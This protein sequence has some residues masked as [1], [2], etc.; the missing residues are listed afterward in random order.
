[1]R[2]RHPGIERLVLTVNLRNAAA[3]STYLK[4]GFQDTGALY[5]GGDSG[6]QH[7]FALPLA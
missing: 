4:A 3:I 7:V 1:M 6:P 5:H 2:Q